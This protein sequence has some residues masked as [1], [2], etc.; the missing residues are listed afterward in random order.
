MK[1]RGNLDF[2]LEL[3]NYDGN[4]EY[5]PTVKATELFKHQHEAMLSGF[6]LS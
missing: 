6:S 4:A 5:W 2:R 3:D 1:G